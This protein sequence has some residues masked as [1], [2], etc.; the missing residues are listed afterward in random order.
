MKTSST[1]NKDKWLIGLAKVCD[2]G[3]SLVRTVFMAV[4]ALLLIYN[5]Y[6]V[7][8]LWAM[9]RGAALSDN[10]IAYKPQLNNLDGTNSSLLELQKINNEAVAWITVDDTAIDYPVLQGPDNYKYVNAKLEGGQSMSGEIFL[11]SNNSSDF[12][13]WYNILYGHNMDFDH[14]FGGLTKYSDINY[15]K[16][17][18]RGHIF[19]P[20]KTYEIEIFAQCN[21]FS[22]DSLFFNPDK[23]DVANRE[24][25]LERVK[26]NANVYIDIGASVNDQI[27]ALSTCDGYA[28]DD[29]IVVLARMTPL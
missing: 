21:A 6:V 12:S 22:S 9:F 7:Y 25:L 23:A 13:D 20:E 27:V 10:V 11:D 16:S 15:M 24:R 26:S 18:Q 28:F 2:F 17:H 19:L 8:D 1:H 3:T 29:R 4:L 5:A 14:M